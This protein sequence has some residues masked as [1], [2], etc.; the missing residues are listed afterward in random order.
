MAYRISTLDA[1]T[2][3]V[4]AELVERNNGIFGGC[5]CIGYYPECGQHGIDHRGV[6]HERVLTDRAHAA[7]VID[8]D[9]V[10]HGWCQWGSPEELSGIKH[11]RAYEKEPPPVPDWR[12]TCIFV[13]RKH[14]GQG[15][16]R[17]ALEG[18]LDQIAKAGGGL[19]EAIFEVTVGRDA[20]GRFLFSG[21]V[22][23]FENYGFQR[24]RQ[25]GKHAYIV[26]RIITL[27]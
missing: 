18:A 9:G 12:I 25:L 8:D 17:T 23:F 11:K 19:V 15:V 24:G 26:S 20:P 14:R 21:T 2:W 6:K 22:E 16:A 3:D 13:D 7:H 1:S 5:W 10:A 27:F 4:F